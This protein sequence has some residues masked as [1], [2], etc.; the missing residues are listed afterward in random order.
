MQILFTEALCAEVVYTVDAKYFF[1]VLFMSKCEIQMEKIFS[2]KNA[3]GAKSHVP[4]MLN[5]Y[6]DI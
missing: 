1:K 4:K 2:H 3:Y 6:G 5:I